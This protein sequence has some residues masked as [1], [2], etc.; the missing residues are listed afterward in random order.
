[1]TFFSG[2]CGL[3]GNYEYQIRTNL[4]ELIPSSIV[5]TFFHVAES[6]TNLGAGP[7]GCETKL[8]RF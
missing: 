8:T 3:Y 2:Y 7:S 1:M 4:I 6:K 5:L